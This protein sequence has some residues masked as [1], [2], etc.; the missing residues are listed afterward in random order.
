PKLRKPPSWTGALMGDQ[1]A[2]AGALDLLDRRGERGDGVEEVGDEEV[3]GDLSDRRFLVL[4]D[5][6]DRLRALHASEVLDGAR[7][8]DR[9]VELRRDDLA[10]LTDLQISADVARVAGGARRTHRGAQGV[11][12]GLEHAG[13]ALGALEGAAAGDDDLRLG[14]LRAL[15][16]DDLEL[17][18][19]DA[20]SEG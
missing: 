10:G 9:D 16:L 13:E 2:S 5:R 4:V 19:L 18:E 3:V 17:L 8:A 7:D 11:D 6:D 14:E 15:A 1:S 12:E 20:A